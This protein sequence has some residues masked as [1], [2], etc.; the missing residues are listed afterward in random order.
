MSGV[1]PLSS[2]RPYSVGWRT[3]V[4]FMRNS[5]PG[6]TYRPPHRGSAT[7]TLVDS[8]LRHTDTHWDSTGYGEHKAGTNR[9]DNRESRSRNVRHTLCFSSSIGS[10]SED[11]ERMISDLRREVHDLRQEAR[12]RSPARERPRHKVTQSKRNMIGFPASHSPELRTKTRSTTICPSYTSVHSARRLNKQRCSDGSRERSPSL[13]PCHKAHNPR[14]KE[15]APHKIA[16]TGEQNVVWKALDLVSSSPYLE[17]ID[18]AEL[19]E[20][21]TAPLFDVYDG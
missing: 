6:T 13:N 12:D 17:R 20:R 5:S 15:Y 8:S 10:R 1:A 16:R 19:P 2:R 18:R 3:S 7:T 21:F 4:D 11:S 9:L 14:R